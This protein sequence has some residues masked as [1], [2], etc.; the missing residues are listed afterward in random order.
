MKILLA[1]MTAAKMIALDW[2]YTAS[3]ASFYAEHLLAE[4]I[5]DSLGDSLRDKIIET[6]YLGETRTVPPTSGEIVGEALRIYEGQK[7]DDPKPVAL[8]SLLAV[9]AAHAEELARNGR[10]SIGTKSLLDEVSQSAYQ[11]IGLIERQVAK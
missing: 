1:Q 6:H 11:S 3:G 2:H 10:L 8:S 5:A 7:A 9:A 4:K